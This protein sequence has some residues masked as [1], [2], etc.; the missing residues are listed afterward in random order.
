MKLDVANLFFLLALSL[1]VIRVTC[2]DDD[3]DTSTIDAADFSG[4]LLNVTR[5]TTDFY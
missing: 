5:F 4:K 1:P 2:Q 3:G